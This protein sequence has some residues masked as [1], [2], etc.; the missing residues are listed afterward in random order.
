MTLTM[1]KMKLAA[2]AA[3]TAA[4]QIQNPKHAIVRQLEYKRAS[5]AAATAPL[6]RPAL[7]R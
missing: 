1:K 2:Y 5:A 7:I 4:C 3:R 6:V